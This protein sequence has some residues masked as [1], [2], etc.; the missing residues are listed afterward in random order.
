MTFDVPHLDPHVFQIW[1]KYGVSPECDIWCFKFG[2][3]IKYH[4][5]GEENPNLEHQMSHSGAHLEIHIWDFFYHIWDSFCHILRV[6]KS[7]IQVHHIR[8]KKYHIWELENPYLGFSSKNP[9]TD[10]N[11]S[12]LSY[13]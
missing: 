1:I 3:W 13:S 10:V 8:V 5:F 11:L 9:P 7:K 2:S 12:H 4:I 6:Q